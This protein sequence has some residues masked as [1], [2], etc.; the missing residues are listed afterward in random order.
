[1]TSYRE[2]GNF[3]NA[4]ART[5]QGM[6]GMIYQTPPKVEMPDAFSDYLLDVTLSNVPFET[7]AMETGKEIFLTGRYGILVDM[8]EETAEDN[9]PYLVGYKAEQITNWR[10]VR[11]GG[12]EVLSMVV[13]LEKVE[14]TDP[15]DT[16]SV[17]LV[18]QFRVVMLNSEGQCIRQLWRQ[19]DNKTKEWI[20]FGEDIVLM[21]RGEALDFVPFIFMGALSPTPEL[22]NPPLIDLADVN[23]AHWRNSVDHEYGLHLVALPTPWI[24]GAKG[25]PEGTTMKIGPSV[26]WELEVQGKAGMLEFTGKGLE[27]LASAMDE[28]KKQMATLGARLLEDQPGTQETASGVRLRHSAETASVRTIAQS[29]EQGF[30]QSLQIVVWWAG[31]DAKPKDAGVN[32]ELNKEY[33]NVKASPEEVRVALTALQAGEMSFETWYHFLEVGGWT[34]EGVTVE[35]ERLA[36]TRGE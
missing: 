2:R 14:V 29:Q 26:V 5:V 6:N 31:T 18:E 8:P 36:I 13:L 21:R 32:V 11:R 30:I 23:L 3:Y 34:R 20:Q 10:S 12:D 4:V 7:F 24:S 15:K 28:K 25:Q 19:K 35:D 16:F 9:R 1:N 22:K 27:S 17:G 33:L